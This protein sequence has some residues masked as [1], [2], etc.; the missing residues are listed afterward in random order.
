[1]NDNLHGSPREAGKAAAPSLPVGT[2]VATRRGVVTEDPAPAGH[3]MVLRSGGDYP[4][5][6][7]VRAITFTKAPAAGLEAGS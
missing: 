4:I 2:E 1:M 3:V 5:P 7:P 6:V